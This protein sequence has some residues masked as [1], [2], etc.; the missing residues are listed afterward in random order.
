MTVTFAYSIQKLTALIEGSDP[1]INE[2][3]IANHYGPEYGLD[4]NSVNQHFA[5]SADGW[6][7]PTYVKL[8]ASQRIDGY[9]V[10]NI[11]VNK[12]TEKD[13]ANFYPPNEATQALTWFDKNYFIEN[14]ICLDQS[15]EIIIKP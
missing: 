9:F 11:P 2:N 3:V 1:N 14:F 7:D 6:H 8:V 10:K 13:Y 4:L 5:F 12:C 15:E